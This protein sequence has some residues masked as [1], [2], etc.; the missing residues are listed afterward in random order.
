MKNG[1]WMTA[2]DVLRIQTFKYPDKIGAKGLCKAFTCKQWNER[3]CR[4]ANALVRSGRSAAFIAGP[5]SSGINTYSLLD[6]IFST[7][8]FR[9]CLVLQEPPY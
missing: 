7:A 8:Q 9:H 2:K 1:L 5:I 3:A 4:L 6:I